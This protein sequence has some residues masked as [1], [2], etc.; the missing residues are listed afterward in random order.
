MSSSNQ[1]PPPGSAA[2]VEFFE[3]GSSPSYE[4][5]S[6]AEAKIWRE[7]SK[8]Y[9]KRLWHQLSAKLQDLIAAVN[10][11]PNKKQ[12]DLVEI[13][14][15][16]IHEFE[17]KLNPLKLVC[18]CSLLLPD[19]PTVDAALKFLE[20]LAGKVHKN[21]FTSGGGGFG[22]VEPP[23]PQINL[24]AFTYARILQGKIYLWQ[25]G[26]VIKTKSILDECEEHLNEIEG[27][28]QVHKEYYFLASEYYK[29]EGDHANFYQASLRYLGVSELDDRDKDTNC[30]IA[31]HLSLAALLGQNVFNFG[32]LLS[33]PIIKFLKGDEVNGWLVDMLGAFN[34]GD[35]KGFKSLRGTWSSQP[36]LAKNE[37]TLYNKICLLS[38]MEMT[39][40]RSATERRLTFAD[41]AEHTGLA[42]DRVE[43]LV[44]RALSRGL[45]K[46][47]ID[48]VE[49]SVHV[50]WVQPR[51]LDRSQLGSLANK[52]D[53]WCDSIAVMEKIIES[54]AGD[55]LTM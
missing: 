21:A 32:E 41:I 23:K 35:V 8:L 20:E 17:G 1:S 33:H 25:K 24:E 18:L 40:Q 51:V 47:Q 11:R 5:Y 9:G 34:R 13:Y 31:V 43:L 27:V 37:D 10:A 36:D 30:S 14:E 42:K 2:V 26:D 53:K 3:S 54:N 15:K 45:I 48:Q 7:C 6:E 29:R 28:V 19:F 4:R 22:G 49:E 44:M 38:V 50:S 12:G 55:I 39:F 52:L 16:G 46:G